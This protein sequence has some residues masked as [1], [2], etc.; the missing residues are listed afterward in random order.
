[1]LMKYIVD[2]NILFSTFFL[3]ELYNVQLK[4]NKNSAIEHLL[5]S[6][7]HACSAVVGFLCC[8]AVSE[9]M[10]EI[11]C[12]ILCQSSVYSMESVQESALKL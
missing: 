6:R 10:Q 8:E 7:V 2:V 11:L 4:E 12:R 5:D 3:Q 1:M 9:C